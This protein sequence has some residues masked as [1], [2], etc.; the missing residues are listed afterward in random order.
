MTLQRMPFVPKPM[1]LMSASPDLLQMYV[2]SMGFYLQHPTLTFPILTHIRLLVAL[3]SDYPYCIDLNSSFLR[4]ALELDDEQLAA[5]RQDLGA[6]P[7][8]DREKELVRFVVRSVREP[9]AIDQGDVDAL[10]ELGWTDS[11][12][13]EAT[14]HGATMV[15]MGIL[16][17]TFKM[18]HECEA[19]S[20]G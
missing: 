17:N 2:G 5:I 12:I 8:P 4:H 11:E 15:S 16:F 10:R 3:E 6:S 9:E 7:L 19:S 14:Y 18:G 20:P 1:Q 13:F